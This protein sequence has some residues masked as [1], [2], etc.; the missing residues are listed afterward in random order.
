MR[1]IVAL[2]ILCACGVP[3]PVVKE[4]RPHPTA[5][6]WN[7]AVKRGDFGALYDLTRPQDRSNVTG[8]WLLY[9]NRDADPV[10]FDAILDRHG[11]G[12][13]PDSNITLAPSDQVRSALVDYLTNVG[14]RRALYVDVLAYLLRTSPAASVWYGEPILWDLRGDSASAQMGGMPVNFERVDGRWYMVHDFL[15]TWSE[16]DDE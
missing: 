4:S 2:S 12:T 8:F 16:I 13:P 5:A 1:A 10:A 7:A 14:N 6:A 15:R 9:L 11:L 3:D